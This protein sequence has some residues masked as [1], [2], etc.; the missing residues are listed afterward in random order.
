MK[1]I[2]KTLFYIVILFNIFNF[3]YAGP[4][5]EKENV[6]TKKLEKVGI[7]KYKDNIQKYKAED[8]TIHT[9]YWTQGINPP[10]M[11]TDPN[12]LGTKG[13]F[14]LEELNGTRTYQAEFEP[15]QG[16]YD[17]NKNLKDRPDEHP[18]C[19]LGAAGNIISWWLE[20]NKVYVD[21]YINR[22]EKTDV[23]GQYEGLYK[24]LPFNSK[25]W[26]DM[27]KSPVEELELGYKAQK[28]GLTPL[29]KEYLKP[30]YY[31][32]GDGYFSNYVFDFYFNGYDA[33]PDL[34]DPPP[35][36]EE[37]F[38][39]DPRGGFFFPIFGR[40]L[41][42]ETYNGGQY[43]TVKYMGE[44]IP[45]FFREGKGIVLAYEV[46]PLNAHAITLWG[47]EL[48][49][50]NKLCRVYITDS[51]D[52]QPVKRGDK[53]WR[54]MV[55]FNVVPDKYGKACLTNQINPNKDKPGNYINH[56]F[57]LNLSQDL[58]ERKLAD[59]T[60]PV[61]PNIISEP[62]DKVYAKG[63]VSEVSVEAKVT[64]SGYIEYKWFV[65]KD[66]DSK[67]TEIK[68]AN[69]K[70]LKIEAREIGE[71]YYYCI[72]SNVKNGKTI[73][74][75]TSHFKVDVQD[76]KLV[77]AETPRFKKYNY[78][79]V[80]Y[81]QY[82]KPRAI[83]ATAE[84]K[85]GGTLTYQWYQSYDN[86]AS[87]GRKLEGETSPLFYP[88]TNNPTN[89]NYYY[90]VVTNTNPNVT[91]NYKAVATVPFAKRIKVIE[92]KLVNAEIPIITKQ[93]EDVVRYQYK[94]PVELTVEAKV[95]DGGILSY[96]WYEILSDGTSKILENET[97]NKLLL[98]TMLLG[99][100]KYKC[101]VKNTNNNA[102][103]NKIA[104][105]FTREVTV[106]IKEDISLSGDNNLAILEVKNAKLTPK[107]NKNTTEYTVLLPHK[108]KKLDLNISTVSSKAKIDVYNPI[109]KIGETKEVLIKV[110]AEN[111]NIKIYKIKVTRSNVH[112]FGEW[113]NV[114]RPSYTEK[115]IEKRVCGVCGEVEY[116]DI[117]MLVKPEQENQ[118]KP[119][120]KPKPENQVKPDYKPEIKEE[121]K[122]ELKPNIQEEIKKEYNK[123]EE[124]KE[125]VKEETKENKEEKKKHTKHEFGNWKIIKKPTTKEDGLEKRTCIICGQIEEKIIPKIE[126]E[127]SAAKFILV[128][129]IIIIQLGSIIYILLK[130]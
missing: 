116:R 15:G 36:T 62:T 101:E 26:Q 77:N 31:K 105:I 117:A 76:I 72:V 63:A 19:Y 128:S 126:K 122:Q 47:V 39:K 22:L 27:R 73:S 60:P 25:M 123:K 129:T 12:L 52:Y 87:N 2:K 11:T 85:D 8:G 54:G 93:P 92:R 94:E 44:N 58:W 81:N 28:I 95:T 110:T 65:A 103:N 86:V 69:K 124:V 1:I 20:Q 5:L 46:G 106:E 89:G 71:K 10:K 51:D 34:F 42:S 49:S 35:N 61:M 32:K 67:G 64:D 57:V 114:K 109:L 23:Y 112:D 17:L 100:K 74:K 125:E 18:L 98:N 33:I 70:N 91:G 127:N 30:Y 119:E 108:E 80:T 79:T 68:G 29:T 121:I 115:G 130:K 21:E 75:E 14:Y 59:K 9:I 50:N 7:G 102:E 82:E 107:F 96:T 78:N 53:Y 45:K 113:I 66:R 99:K 97:E 24:I 4:A 43:N 90:C 84:V 6:N 55:G 104:S 56:I 3:I 118:V 41:I 38:L 120:I 111:T 88:P 40:T 13:Y 16:Y 48:D 37:T 83:D